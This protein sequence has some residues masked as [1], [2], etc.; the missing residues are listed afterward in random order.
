MV[1][2]SNNNDL[3][4]DPFVGSGTT[5]RASKDLKRN[6]IGAEISEDYCKIWEDRLRQQ[7]LI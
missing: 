4:F 5:H 6:F 7:V 2:F 3:I 1:D